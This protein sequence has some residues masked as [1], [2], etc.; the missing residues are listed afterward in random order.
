MGVPTPHP[1]PKKSEKLKPRRGLG[2]LIKPPSQRTPKHVQTLK[3]GY[4]A[5]FLRVGLDEASRGEGFEVEA[6]SQGEA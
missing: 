2:G 1:S 4:S 6:S 3:I 5:I